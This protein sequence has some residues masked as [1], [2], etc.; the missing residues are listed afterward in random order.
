MAIIMGGARRTA[1]GL[2]YRILFSSSGRHSATMVTLKPRSCSCR[3]DERP[4]TPWKEDG[5]EIRS[6]NIRIATC[7]ENGD[8]F[9]M[10]VHRVE[11]KKQGSRPR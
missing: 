5:L 10:E 3:A 6:S 11:F 9:S 8:I 7:A 1:H 2:V 4:T